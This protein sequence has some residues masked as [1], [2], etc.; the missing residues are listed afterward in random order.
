[1]NKVGAVS[2]DFN[3]IEHLVNTSTFT[4]EQIAQLFKK[5][6][7]LLAEGDIDS[8]VVIDQ[9]LDDHDEDMILNVITM[10]LMGLAKN[11]TAVHSRM[12]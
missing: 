11:G 4:E 8:T 9:I 7:E 12:N 3:I 5:C 6:I 2:T 10:L 1:M